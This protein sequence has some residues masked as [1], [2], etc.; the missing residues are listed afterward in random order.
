MSFL[1]LWLSIFPML[2]LSDLIPASVLF[3]VGK[4]PIANK[5]M[6]ETRNF[7]PCIQIK[8]PYSAKLQIGRYSHINLYKHLTSETRSSLQGKSKTSISWR[9]ETPSSFCYQK[10]TFHHFVLLARIYLKI[11]LQNKTQMYPEVDSQ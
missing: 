3:K 4:F 10:Y 11:V 9:W 5:C 8:W 2:E 7:Y 1:K 6:K